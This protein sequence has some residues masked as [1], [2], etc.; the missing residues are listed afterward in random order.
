[1]APSGTPRPTSERRLRRPVPPTTAE[2]PLFV[3]GLDAASATPARQDE[4]GPLAPPIGPRG[5]DEELLA[6]PAS[7]ASRRTSVGRGQM[8]DPDRIGPLDH[9][10]LEG[11]QRIEHAEQ[12]QAAVQARL[13]RAHLGVTAAQRAGAASVDALFLGVIAAGILS[14]TMRWAG[15]EWGQVYVLPIVPLLVFV[16]LVAVGYLFVFTAASGQTVG[17]MLMGIRVVDAGQS[18]TEDGRVS[19]SQALY[20]GALTIPSVLLFGVGFVPALTRDGRAAHDRI[21]HT[22]VVRA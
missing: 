13:D 12:R 15:L 1:V 20:R 4:S 16:L 2:L 6:P 19:V 21:T 22:R 8:V 17:K 9:D 18:G 14:V 7:T 10:L 5:L 11:L 3:K